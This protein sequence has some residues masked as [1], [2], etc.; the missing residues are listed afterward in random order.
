MMNLRRLRPA[1]PSRAFKVFENPGKQVG[2]VNHALLKCLTI[3]EYQQYVG[4]FKRSIISEKSLVEDFMHCN[5]AEHKVIKDQI[6]YEA[7][8]LCKQAFSPTRKYRPVHFCDLRYYPWTL[9]T[10]VEA[11]YSTDEELIAKVKKAHSDGLLNNS[12]MSF[13]NTYNHV[14]VNNRPI[15]HLIKEGMNK[16]NQFLY[17]NT[18]HARAHLVNVDD[19]DKIRMVHGVP[20]LTLM[21]ELML[22]WPFFNFLRSGTTP[23]AWGYEIFNGGIYRI[24]NEVASKAPR[25]NTF[26]AL[27]WT[28]FDKLTP[29]TV[30]DDIHEIWRDFMLYDQ[31]YMPSRDYPKT[32]TDPIRIHRLWE[33]MSKAVKFTP[34][35]LPNGEEWSRRH[36]TI[37]S[38][39]L[40]TQVLDSNVN[41]VIIITCLKACGIRVDE[42][43]YIKVLGDDSFIGIIDIL[44]REEMD[45]L[46]VKIALE[47]KK[48]FGAILNTKKSIISN[49][50]NDMTF[51]GYQFNNSLPFREDIKLLNQL[52]YPERSWSIA[53]LASRAIGIAWSSCG[54]S[55]TV[56]AVCKNVFEYCV[57]IKE[58]E[59][60]PRG[61][62]WIQHLGLSDQI[63]LSSFPSLGELSARLLDPIKFNFKLNHRF[64]PEYFE[65]DY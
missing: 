62:D 3:E 49:R 24:T 18:S 40:Q 47:A 38:G 35:R 14:F 23:I 13:H 55:K 50:L 34:I 48:R 15:V 61:A 6:Y 1:S 57:K 39:L 5:F 31:G 10:S 20:K 16:G 9:S 22:L 65:A 56:Y 32:T 4:R 63:D 36:S 21:V 28:W 17:W 11:P 2:I 8:Q 30:I 7:L 64:W 54:R 33:F 59:P 52:L 43:T 27:D 29:F 44:T 51:L 46:L 25:L 37:S 58:K 45:V 53:Q 26:L 41:Y 12:R 19:P 42:T 60:D